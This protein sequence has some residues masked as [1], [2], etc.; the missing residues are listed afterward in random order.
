M[1]VYLLTV[2]TKNILEKVGLLFV[3]TITVRYEYKQDNITWYIYT[4]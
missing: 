3:V 4:I 1:N 2:I